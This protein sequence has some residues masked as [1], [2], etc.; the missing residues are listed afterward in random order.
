MLY[1]RSIYK[2]IFEL[3][4]YKKKVKELMYIGMSSLHRKMMISHIVI[5]Q[6]LT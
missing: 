5:F 2:A 3:M 6:I 1:E 4:E